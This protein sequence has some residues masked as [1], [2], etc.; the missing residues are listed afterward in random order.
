MGRNQQQHSVISRQKI[1]SIFRN[2]NQYG[3][4]DIVSHSSTVSEQDRDESNK[5]IFKSKSEEQLCCTKD[6]IGVAKRRNSISH[7]KYNEDIASQA[8]KRN[9]LRSTL[10]TTSGSNTIADVDILTQLLD[11]PIY[12]RENNTANTLS[13]EAPTKE[14]IADR[15]A[16]RRAQNQLSARLCRRRKKERM[17]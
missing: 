12:K 4:L 8:R 13:H 10:S 5:K 3:Q 7:L 11:D 6:D 1:D 2:T 17:H 15:R 14:N 16:R 9:S